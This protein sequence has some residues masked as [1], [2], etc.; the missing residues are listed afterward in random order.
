MTCEDRR[1]ALSLLVDGALEARDP[2][3]LFAHLEGCPGCRGFL[4]ALLSVRSAL[5][6]D[7]DAAQREADALAPARLPRPDR[8]RDRLSALWTW[9]PRRPAL[10]LAAALGCAA[11]LLAAGIAIGTGLA[12]RSPAAGPAP[13]ADAPDESG[14]GVV[15]VCALPEYE[16]LSSPDPRPVQGPGGEDSTLR[17]GR[18]P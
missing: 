13:G 15:Y 12:D 4:E 18:R 1:E 6:R 3:G 10:A 11:V 2:A 7:L 14:A 16:V 5:K 9:A 8:R 17:K